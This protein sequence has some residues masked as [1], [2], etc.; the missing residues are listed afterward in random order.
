MFPNCI[1]YRLFYSLESK[2]TSR[3]T[4]VIWVKEP[5]YSRLLRNQVFAVVRWAERLF[6]FLSFLNHAPLFRRSTGHAEAA[7]LMFSLTPFHS[8]SGYNFETSIIGLAVIVI[9][10]LTSPILQ[11]VQFRHL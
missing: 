6:Q 11:L 7:S 3:E 1:C 10:W 8:I 9:R 5:A 2:S 4:S